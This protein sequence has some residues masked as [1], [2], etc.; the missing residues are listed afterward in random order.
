MR[1]DKEKWEKLNTEED[2]CDGERE[3]ERLRGDDAMR[4][5]EL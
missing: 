3:P 5:I 1:R 2:K 4:G